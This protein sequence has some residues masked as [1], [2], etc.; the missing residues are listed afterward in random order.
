[1]SKRQLWDSWIYFALITKRKLK[2][3]MLVKGSIPDRRGNKAISNLLSNFPELL[4]SICYFCL[5]CLSP[6]FLFL[7]YLIILVLRVWICRDSH[8]QLPFFCCHYHKK[9]QNADERESICCHAHHLSIWMNTL[10]N[11][12]SYIMH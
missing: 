5:F 4:H 3:E 11:Y 1:M 2:N 12:L 8:F 7:F 10:F 6:L 9:Y